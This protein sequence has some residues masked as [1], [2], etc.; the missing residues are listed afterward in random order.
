MLSKVNNNGRSIELRINRVVN[1]INKA[2]Y[3]N[4]VETAT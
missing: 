3:L 4:S 1:E 2:E